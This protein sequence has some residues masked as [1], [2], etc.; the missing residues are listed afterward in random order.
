MTKN[1]QKKQMVVELL[2]SF[3]TGDK[4]PLSFINPDKYIQHNLAAADGLE[5]LIAFQEVLASVDGKKVNVVRVFE[6]GDY[7]FAHS[8]NH[9][10]GPSVCFDIFRFENDLIVEHWD[11]C[12]QTP[13]EPNPS[14][15]TLIDG[16]T[17]LHDLEKTESNKNLVHQFWVDVF[18]NRDVNKMSDYFEG[19]YYIQHYPH[20]SDGMSTLKKSIEKGIAEKSSDKT[21]KIHMV[22]GEGNFVLAVLEHVNGDSGQKT[23][24]HDLFRV[25]NDKIVEHWDTVEVIPPKEEWA[26]NNGK[27]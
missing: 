11:C 17:T 16:A 7:V 4:K 26:N 18:I 6:D 10:F 5:G 19:D 14:G 20:L 27:F 9:L 8:E 12:Q 3:E 23:A 15:R 13:S 24:S 2:Q 21:E 25:E 22:L 1:T